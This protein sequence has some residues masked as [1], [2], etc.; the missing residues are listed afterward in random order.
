MKPLQ[1]STEIETPVLVTSKSL[2][3]SVETRFASKEQFTAITLK[4]DVCCQCFQHFLG[5]LNVLNIAGEN[6]IS[7]SYL[8]CNTSVDLSLS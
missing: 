4:A 2:I 1:E 6:L 5:H 8:V 3:L 7:P